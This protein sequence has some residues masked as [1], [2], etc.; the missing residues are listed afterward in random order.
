MSDSLRAQELQC[1]RLLCPPLSTGVCSNSYPLSQW[2]YLTISSCIALFSFFLQSFPASGSFSVSQ[3]LA[4][5]GQST[6]ASASAS[7]VAMNIQAWFPLGLTG[8]ISLLSKWLSRVF[9]STRIQKHQ[10]LALSLLYSPTLTSNNDSLNARIDHHK[11]WNYYIRGS[12]FF[13][14]S[15]NNVSGGVNRNE[16]QIVRNSDV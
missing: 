8:L 2:C 13:F 11:N 7:V 10:F 5:G 16:Y 6:G 14:L 1:A 12:F 15:S 9:S 3:L 4:C